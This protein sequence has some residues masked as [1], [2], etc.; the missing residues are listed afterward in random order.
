MV[1]IFQTIMPESAEDIQATGNH[2]AE[3]GAGA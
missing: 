1:S 2:I 3:S